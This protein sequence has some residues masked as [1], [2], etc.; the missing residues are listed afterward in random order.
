MFVW[1]E[2]PPTA[3]QRKVIAEK[4][5]AMYR[6]ELEDHAALLFRLGHTAK[7]AKARLHANVKW[8]F[9]MSGKAK[10]GGDVDRI[11]D[12]VYRRSGPP[13]PGTPHV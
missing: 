8:D 5:H 6:Q 11:V 12:A 10:H 7:Q 13:S 1:E 2:H 4:R 9:E 3:A